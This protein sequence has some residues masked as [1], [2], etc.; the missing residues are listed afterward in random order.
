MASVII[1][2][3]V[4]ILTVLLSQTSRTIYIRGLWVPALCIIF[5][6]CL[7]LFSDTAVKAA[8][9]GLNLWACVVVPSLLPFFTASAVMNAAGFISAS[10]VL[11]EP[12][13]RPLF[14]LPG[15]S[16]FALALGITSGYPVGAKITSDLRKSGA[17]T[18]SEA[19]RLLAFTN[20]SGPLFIIG[21]VGTGMYGSP[22]IGIFLYICHLLACIT[23]GFLFRFYRN[24]DG[25]ASGGRYRSICKSSNL[26]GLNKVQVS[27]KQLKKRKLLNEFKTRLIEGNAS[28]PDFGTL[29]GNAVRDSVSTVLSVGGFIVIFSVIISLLN[30]TGIIR[31]VADTLMKILPQQY[32]QKEFT[33]IFSGLLSG[34]LEITTGSEQ[35]SRCLSIP[36][37]IKLSAASFIIGWAGL[38]VHSQVM[39]MVAGTDI[40]TRPYLFGKLMQG[41]ISAVYAWAGSKIC[42]IERM[43]TEPALGSGQ[44]NINGFF[45]TLGRSIVLMTVTIILWIA[46]LH[47]L[48]K[49][50]THP[51]K[52]KKSS[53]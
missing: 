9:S 39:S 30:E 29:L 47:L 14:N 38:S 40:N 18:K 11:L 52:I 10:G 17:L 27:E 35:I 41:L 49:R 5:I 32:R 33:G 45:Q 42:G 44:F 2:A 3:S 37:N 51:A 28:R 20:N 13:M 31:T 26:Q 4:V 6:L 22:A 23:V 12:V 1:V 21:A 25:K 19:E 15:C 50:K 48:Q 8:L 46:L 16:S 53:I 36:L 7:I 24:E 43:V 34:M